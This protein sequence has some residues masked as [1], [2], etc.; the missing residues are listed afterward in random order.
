MALQLVAPHHNQVPQMETRTSG[1]LPSQPFSLITRGFFTNTTMYGRQNSWNAEHN[2]GK[3]WGKTVGSTRAQDHQEDPSILPCQPGP[4]FLLL[5]MIFF[6]SGIPPPLTV[7]TRRLWLPWN[8]HGWK[9][10]RDSRGRPSCQ[11]EAFPETNG[12]I[13]KRSSG[14][15][16]QTCNQGWVSSVCNQWFTHRLCKQS[17][18]SPFRS[19]FQGPRRAFQDRPFH[20]KA[21]HSESQARLEE[22][23]LL[24][25]SMGSSS[26]NTGT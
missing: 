15:R 6:K 12:D 5:V 9:H 23:T 19:A 10:L 22:I 21:R 3:I 1:F 26:C 17:S 16:S 4:C 8:D 14:F 7:V 13:Q 25:L 20:A 2:M 11:S 18:W 24:A